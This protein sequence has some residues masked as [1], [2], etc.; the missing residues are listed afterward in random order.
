[1]L[2]FHG[3]VGGTRYT[4]LKN[5]LLSGLDLSHVLT[6]DRCMLIGRLAQP[7]TTYTTSNGELDDH[8]PAGDTVTMLRLVLPVEA[9]R[10]R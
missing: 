6:E 8:A 2:M 5:D 7:I 3:A 4:S 10:S 1:M 9:A